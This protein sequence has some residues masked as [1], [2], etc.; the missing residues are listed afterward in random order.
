MAAVIMAGAM[1]QFLP[2][3]AVSEVVSGVAAVSG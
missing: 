3:V 2:G 1:C